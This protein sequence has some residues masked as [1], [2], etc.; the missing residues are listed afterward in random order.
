MKGS[1]I[2][3]VV[4]GAPRP[5]CPGRASPELRRTTSSSSAKRM[6]SAEVVARVTE[7]RPDIVVMDL[8]LPDGRGRQA[9]EQIMARTPTPILVLSHSLDDHRSPSVVEALVAGA[10]D[11]LPQ[12][13][14]WTRDQS[15]GLCHS[16]RLLRNVHVI[17][18]PREGRS[19]LPTRD[20][21]SAPRR[22]RPSPSLPLPVDRAHWPLCCRVS[23][24]CRH[25][26]SSSSTCI[27][28]SRPGSSSGCREYPLFPSSSPSMECEPGPV[29][30]MSHRATYICASPQTRG[31]SSVPLR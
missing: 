1:Q 29:A 22:S 18:Q 25:R 2:R 4:A 21:P 28:T 7:L 24:A 30:S 9:I 26:S 17:R 16:V 27:P 12:P 31:S 5:S 20:D 14:Q 15:A 11:A 10:L 19:Q 8:Y 3:A 23:A 13:S 6:P